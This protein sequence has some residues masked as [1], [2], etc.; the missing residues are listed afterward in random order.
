MV[1]E[2]VRVR[3]IAHVARGIEIEWQ[4]VV[5]DVDA[6]A[7][8][9]PTAMP[10]RWSVVDSGA[11]TQ[12]DV[13]YDTADWRLWSEGWA[14]RVRTKG[15]RKEAS[16][17]ALARARGGPARR[18]EITAVVR[19]RRPAALA[20]SANTVA[21]RLRAVVDGRA[22]RRLFTVRTRR[23]T[24]VLRHDGRVVAEIALDRTRIAARGRL[25]RLTRVEIEVTGGPTALVAR[26]VA[27]LRRR[28]HL[29]TATRSKF[30]HGLRTARLTPPRRGL[31]QPR[32]AGRERR[33]KEGPS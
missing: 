33:S 17:K 26:F 24:F 7:R 20:T 18:R 3:Q 11:R 31:C 10:S 13:Y 28:R 30:E 2:R 12:A 25:R 21:R 6:F 27:T 4:F 1:V 5:R 9:L 29:G 19:D 23:R 32:A 16:L 22:L 15:T 8:W 14:C